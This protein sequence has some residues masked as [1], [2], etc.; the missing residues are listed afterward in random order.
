[1]ENIVQ[2]LVSLKSAFVHISDNIMVVLWYIWDILETLRF[3]L[4]SLLTW[5]L[6][7][8]LDVL[9]WLWGLVYYAWNSVWELIWWPATV[10]LS[11]LFIIILVRIAVAFVFKF[12]K[13]N[14]DYKK[15]YDAWDR[16]NSKLWK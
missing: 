2:V 16:S 12:F 9:G 3:W 11:S 7:I 4:T 5:V 8:A 1:M 10:I 6:D 13:M 14:L 15:T